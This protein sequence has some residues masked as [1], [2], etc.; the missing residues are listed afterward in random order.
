MPAPGFAPGTLNQGGYPAWI[1]DLGSREA[2]NHTVHVISDLE[3][4]VALQ[5]LGAEQYLI[6]PCQLPA[7]RHDRSTSLPRAAIGPAD[8]SA[9]LLAGRIGAWTFVYDDAGLTSFPAGHAP[10]AKLLSAYGRTA[11][12]STTTLNACTDLASC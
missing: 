11:A 8:C 7:G 4:A 6:T 2:A 3:P 1:A 12:T 5:L 9:V 10:P